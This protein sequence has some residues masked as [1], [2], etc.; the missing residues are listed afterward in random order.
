MLAK[1][2][3]RSMKEKY[4]FKDISVSGSIILKW[5]LK[6]WNGKP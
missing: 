2:W 1:F 5:I 6:K 3:L 4:Y